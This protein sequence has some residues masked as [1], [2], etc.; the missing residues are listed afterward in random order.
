M[1]IRLTLIGGVLTVALGTLA[2]PIAPATAQVAWPDQAW[3]Q[4]APGALGAAATTFSTLDGELRDGVYGYVD[5]V[6][7]IHRG[8]AVANWTYTRD[9]RAI[10]R[11][12]VSPIGCGEGCTDAAW[13]HEFNYLHPNWHPYFQGRDLHTLQSVTK[14]IAA[15]VVGVAIG[16]GEVGP[17]DR[18]FL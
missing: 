8:Q 2:P 7:V 5:R 6:L 3:P 11:G 4:A 12:R 15:T 10:S 18:P 16:R 17:V 14:T 1:S 13:M 9:Y